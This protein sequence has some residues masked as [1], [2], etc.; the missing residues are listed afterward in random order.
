MRAFAKGEPFMH[1]SA[2]GYSVPTFSEEFLYPRLGKS[3]ARFVLAV[4]DEYA[5]LIEVLG[6]AR[7]LE[8]LEGGMP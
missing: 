7:V 2:D 5:A 1:I 4:A 6:E 8:L 3:E